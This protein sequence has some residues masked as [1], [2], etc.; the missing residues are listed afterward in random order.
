M[1]RDPAPRETY[2]AGQSSGCRQ[3]PCQIAEEESYR[4]SKDCALPEQDLHGPKERLARSK[5]NSRSIN[6]ELLHKVPQFQDANVERD[7]VVVTE[8][9]LDNILRSQRRL[10]ARASKSSKEILP[11][12]PLEERVLAIQSHAV[13]IER[14][15]THLYQANSPRSEGSSRSRDLVPPISRR[16]AHHSCIRRGLQTQN[17]ASNR[18]PDLTGVD[19][20]L[21]E[22][23]PHPSPKI[24]LA[25]SPVRSKG[26][27]SND[28]RG[29]HGVIPASF[30]TTDNCSA[31]HG[32]RDH[33]VT[34]PSQLDKPPRLNSQTIPP[35]IK[36]DNQIAKE[37]RNRYSSLPDLQY[38]TQHLQL[39]QRSPNPSELGFSNPQYSYSD[40]CMSGGVGLPDKQTPLLRQVRQDNGIFNKY[41][42]N[43]DSMV[44]LTDGRRERSCYP[45]TD[46]QQFSDRGNQDEFVSVSPP[47]VTV[48]DDLE[49]SSIPKVDSHHLSH[50]R[51]LQC[52]C[53]P[54]VTTSRAVDRMVLSKEG[55]PENTQTEPPSPSGFIR[56]I[57]EQ[58]TPNLCVSVP[59]RES[60]SNRC[61][62]ITVEQVETPIP[63][64]SHDLDF[65]GFGED[66]RVHIRERGLSYSRYSNKTM[67]HV[68]ETQESSVITN[69]SPFTASSSRPS[70]RP[71]PNYKTSRLAAIKVPLSKKFLGSKIIE[72]IARPNKLS[73]TDEYQAK[74]Q[75][76]MNYLEKE[77]IHPDDVNDQYTAEFFESLHLKGLK[78]TTVEHY[79]TALRKPLLAKYGIDVNSGDYRDLIRNF[80]GERPNR[81][82]EDPHWNL[83]KVLSYIDEMPDHLSAQDLLRKTAFLLLLATGFRISELHACYRTKQCCNFTPDNYL[84]LRP[85]PLFLA[86]NE[87][88]EKRWKA[89]VVKP[90]PSQD[91]IVNK[92]CPVSSLRAFLDRTPS[93]SK[94]RL[95]RSVDGKSKELTKHQLSVEVCK[96]ILD[97]DPGTKARVHDVRSYA[98]SCS[99]AMTMITPTELAEAIGWSSPATFYKFY[100]KAIDPLYREVSLPGPDPRVRF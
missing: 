55:L 21:G 40:R 26:P 97:A 48:T 22:V 31:N 94:G 46:R 13:R 24:H 70:S 16:S 90:L 83:N 43:P 49:E 12:L 10:L 52:H 82:V 23:T 19:P 37:N 58:S 39:D 100:R 65:E 11:M 35:Q 2:K 80:K 47:L 6:S 74:W 69:R 15:S 27:Y 67:V 44:C 84:Q 87:N 85:H 76:F 72:R 34:R 8:E 36:E 61:S 20:E 60:N 50:T 25:G 56:H 98:A 64:P 89:K 42:G 51:L 7:K 18:D 99:L 4:K 57:P 93:K 88:P 66:D 54:T 9:F 38:K 91:G 75:A 53:R 79:K 32:A 30:D 45:G 14:S 1:G 5:T 59:R 63:V 62:D 86:K 33:A 3:Y 95:F 71:T 92:L 17:S 73:T 77:G 28:S 41:P 68:T 96:L 78:P 81:V 29:N